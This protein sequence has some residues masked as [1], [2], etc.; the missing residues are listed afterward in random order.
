MGS[1][2]Y[3]K[4]KA[5]WSWG[6]MHASCALGRRFESP[7]LLFFC[8]SDGYVDLIFFLTF[9]EWNSFVQVILNHLDKP[10]FIL[11][12]NK[13]EANIIVSLSLMFH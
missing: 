9:F 3:L 1:Y 2:L 5:P 7:P 11:G 6:L 12:G 4:T 13:I 8:S 10:I